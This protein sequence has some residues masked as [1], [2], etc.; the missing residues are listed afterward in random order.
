LTRTTRLSA[1]AALLATGAA[2]VYALLALY[3]LRLPGVYPDELIHYLPAQ[4]LVDGG[5]RPEVVPGTGPALTLAGHSLQLMT[6]SY[7][8]SLKTVIL[9]PFVAVFGVTPSLMRLVGI[10]MGLLAL[11]ATYLFGRRLFR[12]PTVA[13][14]SVALLA[15]DPSFFFYSRID[16]GPTDV[17]LLAKAF[18][19]WQLLRWW[20]TGS[21]LSLALGSLTVGLGLWDKLNF[22]WIVASAAL[23]LAVVAGREVV[24]RLDWNTVLV[25]AGGFLL[26]VLPLLAYNLRSH[27]SSLSAV[28]DVGKGSSTL[29]AFPIDEPHA[30]SGGL[31]SQLANRFEVLWRLLD[32]QEV[33]RLVATS[34]PAHFP[35]LSAAFLLGALVACTGIIARDRG[36]RESRVTLFLLIFGAGTLLAAAATS[37]AFHGHHV[38]LVYPVPH[39]LLAVALVWAARR[40]R[41]LAVLAAIPLSLGVAT[42]VEVVRT[43]DKTD[44]HGLWS[45]RIY[46]LEGYASQMDAHDQWVGVDWGLAPPLW[47][48]SQGRLRVEDLAFFLEQGT[49]PASRVLAGSLRDP[50]SRYVLHSRADTVYPVARRRFFRALRGAGKRPKLVRSFRGRDGRPIYEVYAAVPG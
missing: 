18:A 40:R 14:L 24:R 30:P 26:G 5:A 1:P 2:A 7:L 27:F 20:D 39:M 38:I 12:D 28:A 4:A 37:S 31:L 36:S 34:L 33:A 47:G 44:G 41:V 45:T 6:M 3:R 35:E 25:A 43:M 10:A 29:G 8:G 17:M 23:A 11:A 49:Q 48:L 13:A 42:T 9:A 21:R 22:G 19:A 32:G 15:L 50:H 16:W 46:D